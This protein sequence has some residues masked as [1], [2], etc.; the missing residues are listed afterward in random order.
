[1]PKLADSNDRIHTTFNQD[2]ASTGRLSSTN[3]NLQNI[4]IRTALGRKIR[5]AFVAESGN[6]LV[7]ADY[8]QFELRLAAILA[9]DKPL[10][11]DFNQDVD[12]HTKTASDSY[13]IDMSQVTKDQRRAAKVINFGV[14]YGMSPHGLSA[15][16]GMSFTA[17]KQFIDQYF[18]LRKP[19]RQFI[20]ATLE[21][22]KIDGYVETYHGRR[23]P[24]PDV[25][26]SNFMVR[27]AAKR[28]AANMPIQGT[29]ADLMKLAMIEVD[30]KIDGLGEQIL[31]IHD[32]ILVECPRSNAEQI[33]E[34]L[35]STMENIAPEL[36]VKLK[37]DVSIGQHWGEL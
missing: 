4:P 37:V 26:S 25:N 14:L 13:G 27:E 33:A 2:V 20:D 6:V 21:R 24:T 28:A 9:D 1:M 16:T 15:A 7:S 36:G 10:I 11:E 34:I 29:E 8:S 17:A 35:K 31:Q 22:A 19:I 5:E 18:E 23:R 32:S 12:I 3:P 30:K